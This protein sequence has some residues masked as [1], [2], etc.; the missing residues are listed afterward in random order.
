MYINC[1]T[2]IFILLTLTTA[3]PTSP[4]SRRGLPGAYYTCTGQNFAGQCSWTQPN[5]ECHIQGSPGGI[6]SLGPDPGSFCTLYTRSDCM[7]YVVKYVRFPGNAAVP[8]FGSF[9][10]VKEGNGKR[11]AEGNVGV[12][13][14]EKG[15]KVVENEG[16]EEGMIGVEKGVYY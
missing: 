12:G 4:L 9:E 16:R 5:T 1:L 14:M 3:S 11:E 6:A 10:C 2:T 13:Y 7:G 15:V 8:K